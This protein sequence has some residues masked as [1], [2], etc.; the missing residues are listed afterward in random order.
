VR[1]VAIIYHDYHDEP[2]SGGEPEGVVSVPAV[3]HAKARD[4][5]RGVRDVARMAYARAWASDYAS[6]E[7]SLSTMLV[8]PCS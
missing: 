8:H 2:P 1:Q 5:F 3:R 6:A 7:A 4:V